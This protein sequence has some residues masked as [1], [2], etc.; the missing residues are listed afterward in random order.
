MGLFELHSKILVGFFGLHWKILVGLFG[1]HWKVKLAFL[2]QEILATLRIWAHG[3]T[4][5]HVQWNI[6]YNLINMKKKSVDLQFKTEGWQPWG[7]A[8]IKKQKYFSKTEFY[9]LNYAVFLRSSEIGMPA[10][11]FADIHNFTL[12]FYGYFTGV[13]RTKKRFR[14]VFHSD[15]NIILK[16]QFSRL[17]Q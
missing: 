8:R 6:L 4:G 17:G 16:F 11:T 12:F 7:E 1:L 14:A 10:L 9:P 5:L 2:W 13:R 15:Y 3:S